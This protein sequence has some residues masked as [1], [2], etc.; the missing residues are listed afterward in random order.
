MFFFC[1][2]AAELCDKGAPRCPSISAGMP[3]RCLLCMH[4]RSNVSCSS[5]SLLWQVMPRFVGALHTASGT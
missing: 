5:W 3:C 1:S 2:N 4:L